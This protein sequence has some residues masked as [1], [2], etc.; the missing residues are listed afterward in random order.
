MDFSLS[1]V[2]LS[3][4]VLSETLSGV[5]VTLQAYQF[6]NG[7]ELVVVHS[8]DVLDVREREGY[9]TKSSR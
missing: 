1:A 2:K 8:V 5:F 6:A 3:E 4:E 7:F 9:F